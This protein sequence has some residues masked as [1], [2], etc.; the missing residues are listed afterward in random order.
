MARGTMLV[1][2]ATLVFS[3]LLGCGYV[4]GLDKTGVLP[5]PPMGL[6][7]RALPP[8]TLSGILGDYGD[9]GTQQCP[10]GEI[11][12]GVLNIGGRTLEINACIPLEMATNYAQSFGLI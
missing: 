8:E 5:G 7:A 1:L 10:A 12:I 11:W 9:I 4:P 2:C 3:L 6:V